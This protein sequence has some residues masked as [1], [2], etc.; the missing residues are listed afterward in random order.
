MCVEIA[1]AISACFL[2]HIIHVFSV[3]FTHAPV[4]KQTIKQLA[5]VRTQ[6]IPPPVC[7]CRRIDGPARTHTITPDRD[8]TRI[9]RILWS[10][11][12]GLAHP[13]TRIGDNNNNTD[14]VKRSFKSAGRRRRRWTPVSIR[15]T[16]YACVSLPMFGVR[17]TRSLNSFPRVRAQ[18]DQEHPC[19]CARVCV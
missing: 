17:T 10:R 7:G 13:L 9:I 12:P 6:K 2:F 4:C 1:N 18:Q 19:V 15:S 11:S 14:Y 16:L 5:R 8:G 3:K